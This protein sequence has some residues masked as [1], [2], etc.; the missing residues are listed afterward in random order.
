[1][2]RLSDELGEAMVLTDKRYKSGSKAPLAPGQ[3]VVVRARGSGEVV[4]RGTVEEILPKTGIVR[5][6]DKNSGTEMWSDYDPDIYDIWVD[7]QEA[8]DQPKSPDE[9]TLYVRPSLSGG[10]QGGR[11]DY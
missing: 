2:R 9:L 8:V 11:V 1:M 5:V 7:D 3:D 6:S 4:Q 10:Y